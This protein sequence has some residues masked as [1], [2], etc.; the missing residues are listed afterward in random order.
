MGGLFYLPWL[1]ARDSIGA[2]FVYTKGAV[3][4]AT[5][6]GSWQIGRGDS[7]GVGWVADGIFDN[8]GIFA[9][10]TQAPIHLTNAWSVNAGYEHFWNPRWRTSL[11]GGYTRVWYDQ[12]AT[13]IINAAPAGS[14][15]HHAVRCPGRGRCVAA[16]EH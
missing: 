14:C 12:D 15:G 11:Y 3:G 16:A 9:V 2:S 4:Y 13:N 1:G 8:T 10:T 6:A 5:K 7:V